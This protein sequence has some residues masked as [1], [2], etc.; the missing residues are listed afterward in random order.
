MG[1]REC[2]AQAQ[3]VIQQAER[4]AGPPGMRPEHLLLALLQRQDL[5]A[6]RLLSAHGLLA[7]SIRTQL[8]FLP[9]RKRHG[10]GRA[11]L[12]QLAG[13]ACSEAQM[14]I[15]PE[16]LLIAVL[17]TKQTRTLLRQC[18]AEPEKILAAAVRQSRMPEQTK[19]ETE[20]K[21]LRLLEQFAQDMAER[22]AVTDPVIGRKRE[23]DEI[24][25]ILCR[26]NK[27]NPALVG[28]PGVGKTAVAEEL[29]RRIAAGSVPPQIAGK[30]LYTLDMASL[31]AGTKY[32]GEFEERV[33]DLLAEIRRAG[34]IILFIDEMHTLIGAGSA[35]GAIDAANIIKPALG[36][37]E[38]Q[39]IGATT[40][41]EYRKY[42]EKDAALD[43]R[44]RQV[45]IEEPSPKEA[46]EILVGL[47]PGLELYHRVRI[48]DDA[49]R[50]AVEYS[51][52]YLPDRYLPD[53]ALDLLDESA[54]ATAMR[55]L[56]APKALQVSRQSVAQT[57]ALRTG[58]PAGRITQ[59][60]REELLHLEERLGQSVIGQDAAV[61]KVSAAVR[62]GRSG[63][64]DRRRPI[65][66]VLL[67]GPTGV[68]KTALCK[69]LAAE[70][71]G[72]EDALI[73]LDMSEYT[74]KHT[75]SRLLGAPPGYV[76][77]GEGGELTEKVRTRPYSLV[78]LD[79]LE[80]AHRDVT[81][82]LLQLL[83]DGRLTD[84]MGRTVDFRN[85]LVVMT[86][87]A[88]SEAEGHC[89]MG[90]AGQ[91]EESAVRKR[92]REHFSP[93]LL[94]RMDAIA[95]F[96]RLG[97]PELEK[98]AQKV[99]DETVSR[100]AEAG[101]LLQTDPGAAAWIGAQCR[102]EGGA[103]QIRHLVQSTVEDP[104]SELL[105]RSRETPLRASVICQDGTLRVC[106]GNA[107][108]V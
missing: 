24:I 19:Q 18:G 63:L 48:P 106:P 38:L 60:E 86:T 12:I 76:G 54:A 103:R 31:V 33:R 34:N 85:T 70:V 104:L 23:L 62:R 57:V 72:R 32:R 90:F 68:G 69:A 53:K 84:A 15:T 65:A 3:E 91:T 29:A 89:A 95:V 49:L 61:A 16:H 56:F 77:H 40:R 101:V 80:K 37:G 58:I 87:N 6:G 97:L 64:A 4:I 78:L 39:M 88:G 7:G 35:E 92:L 9:K 107:L 22:A 8:V 36:R 42:I 51:V 66:A 14:R 13:R 25:N 79:E 10:A 11:R 28:E 67:A 50:A 73:R 74:E 52:R 5:P 21:E 47:R 30:H 20:R 83:E 75:V 46:E 27:N 44:F 82:I 96:D 45:S 100:A 2:T 108:P 59:K 17:R 41:S 102:T 26:K 94:G 1:K 81:G 43:R 98:I 93:E 55:Q 99:L 105:L 71:Y